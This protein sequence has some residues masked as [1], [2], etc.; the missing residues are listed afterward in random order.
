MSIRLGPLWI[1]PLHWWR[2]CFW[3]RRTYGIIGIF[4]NLPHIKPGRW[5]VYILGLE[6]GSRNP[7]NPFGCRLKNVGLWPW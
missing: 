1:G 6:I 2:Y 4:R 7:G 3:L 5:G